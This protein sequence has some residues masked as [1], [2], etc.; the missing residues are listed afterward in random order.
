MPPEYIFILFNETGPM[1]KQSVLHG[2]GFNSATEQQLF[3]VYS[4][5]TAATTFSTVNPNFLKE[6]SRRCAG[7]KPFMVTVVPSRPTYLPPSE[8]AQCLYR[9]SL[10]NCLWKDL[11]PCNPSGCSSNTSML[12]MLTTYA[13]P[14]P[15][16]QFCLC[17]HCQL[18]L[19][20]SGNDDGI[21]NFLCGIFQYIGSL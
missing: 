14:R 6:L 8:I 15:L 7:A 5:F 13:H 21:R 16:C 11:L 1:K 17:T 4:D 18:H 10:A 20:T 12:G 3:Y 2:S 19:G 9:H